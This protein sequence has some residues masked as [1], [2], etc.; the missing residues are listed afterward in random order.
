M[1]FLGSVC[2]C[3]CSATV[4]AFCKVPENRLPAM[5]TVDPCKSTA[6]VWALSTITCNLLTAMGAWNQSY[7]AISFL[8]K[9]MCE[10]HRVSPSRFIP[11]IWR[12]GQYF[13]TKKTSFRLENWFKFPGFVRLTSNND[14]TACSR[15]E[16]LCPAAA[17]ANR[18][19]LA[20]REFRLANFAYTRATLLH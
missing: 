3:K 1:F 12:D 5:H 10:N 2:F 11:F 8:V 16:A 18:S 9:T 6:V 13:H 20:D 4:W 15:R 14:P 17:A 19:V 7:F